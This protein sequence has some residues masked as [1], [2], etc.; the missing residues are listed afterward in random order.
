MAIYI[1]F[2][3]TCFS[4]SC[5]ITL[6]LGFLRSR[7]KQ[8]VLLCL[9]IL[10]CE[11]TILYWVTATRQ[12]SGNFHHDHTKSALPSSHC[13]WE[14]WSFWVGEST[15][16]SPRNSNCLTGSGRGCSQSRNR[17]RGR[18]LPRSNQ[19]NRWRK[20]GSQ[21]GWGGSCIR[22]ELHGPRKAT[23]LRWEH[24][25]THTERVQL[26]GAR[27]VLWPYIFLPIHCN[28]CLSI[29]GSSSGS[30][31]FLLLEE[32]ETGNAFHVWI[33]TYPLPPFPW[34]FTVRMPSLSGMPD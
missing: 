28:W 29:C 13:K 18:Q 20:A 24:T 5:T 30:Q 21:H 26:M 22:C 2:S 16:K 32:R 1:C 19:G 14:S 15:V 25:W 31:L 12:V 34:Y 23:V 33:P 10:P 8:S 9:P 7:N 17:N 6:Q 3:G 11:S 27:W 4:Y